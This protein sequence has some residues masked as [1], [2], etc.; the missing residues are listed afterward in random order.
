MQSR[1]MAR[2]YRRWWRPATFALSTR[3]G[4]PSASREARLVLERLEGIAGPR[5]DLS[6]GPG[7]F[8]RHL[9][10][11]AARAG[12]EQPVFAVDLSRAMLA[13]V[14]RLAPAALRVRADAADLPFAD[15]GFG[16]V[17]NL[18]A[19][20]LY[21]DPSRAV[22][23]AARVLRPGGR[24]IA[25]S[26]VA[27]PGTSQWSGRGLPSEEGIAAWAAAAGLVQFQALHFRHYVLAWADKPGIRLH[28]EPTR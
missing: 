10:A 25:S 27:R 20:D 3:N 23:E 13:Q 4:A 8:T 6:C 15:A 28:N 7:A 14:A 18:A 16:A 1:W 9:V 21:P 11:A 22:A 24:W 5:L 17:V 26:F 2:I 12:D 19:L